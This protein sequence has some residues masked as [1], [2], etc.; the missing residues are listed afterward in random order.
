MM[1]QMTMLVDLDRCIGCKGGCQVGC[2][3]QNG[4]AL[5]EF[6]CKVYTMGPTG[7]YPDLE[8][9]FLPVMCQQCMDP[10]CVAVCP[11]GACYKDPED[12]VIKI[13]KASCIGCQ[14]CRRAC[15]YEANLFNKE[16]RVVDK[17]DLCASLRAKGEEPVCVHNCAGAA[18]MFGDINDPESKVR[19]AMDA[20]GEENV[21]TLPDTGAHPSVRYILRG[22]KWLD[23][24][25]HEY[26][27]QT[28]RDG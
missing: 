1:K 26:K 2:K 23:V 24:L 25:P 28:R 8:M 7:T 15:P 5:G 21:Y 27:K 20:A 14:S 17:C 18:L 3:L 19:K 9:Y 12:G 16:L 22:A 10:A 13:D 11:T 4:T 6:R